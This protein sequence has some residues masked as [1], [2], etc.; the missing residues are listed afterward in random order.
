MRISSKRFSYAAY[1]SF[2]TR[3]DGTTVTGRLSDEFLIKKH[4]FLIER[5]LFI[6]F[7]LP[8]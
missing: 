6:R 7:I 4:L 2:V 3:R 5:R 8:Q 1:L